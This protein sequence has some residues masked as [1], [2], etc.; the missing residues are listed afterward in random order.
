MEIVVK[1]VSTQK[2]TFNTDTH[3]QELGQEIAYS[4]SDNDCGCWSTRHGNVGLEEDLVSRYGQ[5]IANHLLVNLDTSND[6]EVE[7]K[8]EEE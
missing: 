6:E 3:D 1:I 4:V 7:W 2:I 8:E 5:K